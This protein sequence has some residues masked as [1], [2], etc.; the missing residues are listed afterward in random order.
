MTE[1]DDLMDLLRAK[2]RAHRARSGSTY[3]VGVT[4]S[5]AVGKSTLAEQIAGALSQDDR[6]PLVLNVDGFLYSNAVLQERNLSRR[7]GYPESY[8]FEAMRMALGAIKRGER[9]SIPRYSHVTYDIDPSNPRVVERPAIIVL[10][11]LHLGS[12]NGGG[13][14]LI[15]TQLYLDAAEEVVEKW[16]S[17]RLRA[18]MLQGREDSTSF[19][20]AFRTMDDPAR[21]A[22][23][24]MV[25]RDI[26]LPNL[27][28][29]IVLDRERADIIA[30]KAADHAIDRIDL[31]SIA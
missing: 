15:D 7:K 3:I 25:W 17:D 24:K 20:Y 19:Y 8:D 22:F 4:G 30:H 6:E 5:V 2:A 28:N 18:L 27:R 11:G 13:E 12:I 29:H 14:T 1:F 23:I 10:D 21:E 31:K 16:F 9:V 26:N